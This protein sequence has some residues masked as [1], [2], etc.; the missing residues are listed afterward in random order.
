MVPDNSLNLDFE[1]P[2][3]ETITICQRFLQFGINGGLHDHPDVWQPSAGQP[4]FYRKPIKRENEIDI[5]QGASIRVVI[6]KGNKLGICFDI[7]HK[8]VSQYPLKTTLTLSD[9]RCYKGTKCV[10]HWGSRWY[11]IKLHELSDLKVNEYQIVRGP[12]E[13]NLLKADIMRHGPKPFPREVVDLDDNGSVVIYKTGKDEIKGAPSALCYPSFDTNDPLISHFHQFTILRP[14]LRRKEIQNFIRVV[15]D[16]LC[17]WDTRIKIKEKP[18]EIS[19]NTFTPPDFAFGHNFVLSSRGSKG[20]THVSLNELGQ[21]RLNALFNSQI[22]PYATEPLDKQYFIWPKSVAHSYGSAFLADLKQ[23]VNRLYPSEVPFEPE[24][25]EYDDNGPKTYA[26]QGPAILQAIESKPYHP[27]YGI[28]MIH[29]DRN[30]RHHQEDQLASMIMRELRKKNLFVSVIHTTVSSKSYVLPANAPS[31][32]TYKKSE[33]R[34]IQGKLE[35]YLRNVA[36]TKVLLTNEKWPFV[37]AT[38]LH[39]DL[40]VGIDVKHH[41]ACFSFVDKTGSNVRTIIK[42]SDQKEKLS[43]EQV[44]TTLTEALREEYSFTQNVIH[45]IVFHRDGRFYD[46]EKKGIK[47]AIKILQAECA[48]AEEISINFVEVAKSSPAP[49]RLF[50]VNKRSFDKEYCD[51]PEIGNYW[52]QSDHD[53]YLCSTGRAFRKRGTVNPL[54]VKYIEGDQHF[55]QILEDLFFLTGLAWTRPEDCTRYPLTIKL[56]DIRLREHGGKVRAQMQ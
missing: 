29:E 3:D 21:A 41:T 19:K 9:F 2:S 17:F 50:E 16:S 4:F 32:I 11:D 31:G 51:N 12:N 54:H 47:A 7:K 15:R 27:G 56:G 39:F 25:I 26:K 45:S 13:R 49:V 33:D 23:M 44:K 5:F 38:P 42:N 53:A 24:L 22:G 10:Y 36:I 48:L 28:V 40:T 20:A 34:K 43:R 8:Y 30:Q 6:L 14:E 37:L 18:L 35:G 55:E 46:T 52:L 1:N